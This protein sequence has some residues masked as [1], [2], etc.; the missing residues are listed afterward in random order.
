MHKELKYCHFAVVIA[1]VCTFLFL[2][3]CSHNQANVPV[4]S[5]QK[6]FKKSLDSTELKS[7]V[8]TA[9]REH[10]WEVVQSSLSNDVNT[11]ELK[12]RF[13]KY[14]RQTGRADRWKRV[15]KEYD[16]N[17][18]VTIS[19]K[20]LR[21]TPTPQS[22][23]QIKRYQQQHLFNEELAKLESMIYNNLVIQLL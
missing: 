23:Q 5:I 10:K 13:V 11:I 19:E 9:A 20:S 18:I 8:E 17:M 12:K 3:G 7:L 22:V 1:G 21:M 6:N 4:S 16:I 15:A 2:S 14:K